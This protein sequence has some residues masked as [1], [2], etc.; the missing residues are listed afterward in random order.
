MLTI[1]SVSCGPLSRGGGDRVVKWRSDTFRGSPYVG[2]FLT[3]DDFH[4]HGIN[5][6]GE[7]YSLRLLSSREASDDPA[8]FI[9][10]ASALSGEDAKGLTLG[11]SSKTIFFFSGERRVGTALRCLQHRSGRY[12]VEISMA[13]KTAEVA[14]LI[15]GI[16]DASSAE[17]KREGLKGDVDEWISGVAGAGMTACYFVDDRAVK[18]FQAVD[19]LK[20]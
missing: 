7:A 1:C 3:D 11:Y 2:I 9:N 5:Y 8:I 17:I 10:D 14:V 12:A 18:W 20:L 15:Y 4:R 19:A 6:F 13:I 16:T